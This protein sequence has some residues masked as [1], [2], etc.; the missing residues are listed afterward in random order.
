MSRLTSDFFVSALLRTV[1]GRGDYATIVKK[2]ASQAGAIFIVIRD[3]A[4]QISLYGP[5][6]QQA[7]SEVKGRLFLKN[8]LVS[9]D[10]GLDALMAKESRFDPDYWLVELELSSHEA[11]LPFDTMR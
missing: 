3:R 11:E 8:D 2:G 6:P 4:G 10:L 5:A 7:Y 1:S 9:D